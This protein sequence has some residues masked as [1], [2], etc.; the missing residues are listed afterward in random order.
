MYQM[1]NPIIPGFYPDPSICRAGSDY[2]IATS[3]F[4]FF[5]GIPLWHSKDLCHWENIGY[6]LD[7]HEQLRMNPK[8]L[9]AGTFAPT[10]R[11]H[12]GL[13]YVIVGN[14]STGENIVVTATDPAGDWSEPHFVE[15][16]GGDPDLFWDDEG[17]CWCAFSA[18]GGPHRGIVRQKLD[19]E[20]WELTGDPIFM[21]GGAAV[22][23]PSPEA[24]HIYKIG[25]WY[26][27]MIAEGGTEH[28]HAV[29]IAR[30]KTLDGKFE[31]YVG[32][33][34]LTHRHLKRI[35]EI[36]N[37]GHADLV[38]T[39]NGEWYM[40]ALASRPYGGYHKNMGRET[41]IA[42]VIWEDG[43]PVVSPDTGK[44]E[45]TYPAPNLEQF[46]VVPVPAKDGFDSQK[47]ANQWVTIGTPVNDP[48]YL[49]DSKLHIKTL[50]DPI[51]TILP[52]R[53]MPMMEGATP[54]QMA[55]MRKKM[56]EERR[57]TIPYALSFVG[58]RQ[59]H[60]SFEVEAEMHFEIK[61]ENETAGIVLLQNNYNQIRLEIAKENGKQVARVIKYVQ[62]TPPNPRLL[63]SFSI[64]EVDGTFEMGK[65]E[66][67]GTNFI[68]QHIAVGQANSFYIG[69]NREHMIAVAENIS[70]KFLGSETAGGF[71]GAFVGMFASGNG[72]DTGNEAAF[73]SF[74]YVGK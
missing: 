44:V 16:I 15:G 43:W 27:L 59:Q 25:D 7:R 2:Y 18:F 39:Q 1:N 5:P 66:I 34:I 50:A 62:I 19:T 12:D 28:M 24:P 31:G 65:V 73:D 33:P 10:I 42:P 52:P 13:F 51:Q 74:T 9:S 21:W 49:S 72:R 17:T 36:V 40:V 26:Y 8:G 30:S 45:M 70:G 47:L 69:K 14:M 60:M 6:A 48:F 37:V 58:R 68:L 56:M 22:D 11:Y 64:E 20:K 63:P 4:T 54:E 35:S 29:T 57:G 38:E 3:S 41:F 61:D 53:R 71:I 32:N 23:A 55:E 67:D 46:P